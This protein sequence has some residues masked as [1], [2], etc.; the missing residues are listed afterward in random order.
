[1]VS[2]E[3]YLGFVAEGDEPTRTEQPEHP[4]ADAGTMQ[5]ESRRAPRRPADRSEKAL[6]LEVARLFGLSPR[7]LMAPAPAPASSPVGDDRAV[8]DPEADQTHEPPRSA[9]SPHASDP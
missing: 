6:G 3:E 8:T 9:P 5:P 7:L 4:G 2:D 1:M